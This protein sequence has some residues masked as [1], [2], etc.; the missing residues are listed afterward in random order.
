MNML[1]SYNFPGNIRELENIIERGIITA[2]GET[3]QL[4]DS[5]EIVSGSRAAAVSGD[6][7]ADM[8]RSHILSILEETGWRIQGRLGAAARLGLNSGTLRSRMKKLGIKRPQPT[9]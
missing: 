9:T 8:E 5:L 4:D 1:Q 3:L 7:L 6:S 2:K